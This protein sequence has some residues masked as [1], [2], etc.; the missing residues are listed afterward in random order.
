MDEHAAFLAEVNLFLAES[1]I[2]ATALGRA[3]VNDGHFVRRLRER[4]GVTL[5][6]VGR[7]RTYM[8]RHRAE[9]LAKSPSASSVSAAVCHQPAV[10]A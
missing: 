8:A 1:G 10:S 4:R 6:T 5:A 2:A 3:A 7:V 9:M